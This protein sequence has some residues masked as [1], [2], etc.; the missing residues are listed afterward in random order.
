MVRRTER[1]LVATMKT[2]Q[3]HPGHAAIS[4]HHHPAQPEP[5][6]VTWHKATLPKIR[7]R[8]PAGAVGEWRPGESTRR[9]YEKA[10][11]DWWWL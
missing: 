2:T 11:E 8:E 10:V 6:P 4:S 7:R 9:G 1:V 3:A 5:E